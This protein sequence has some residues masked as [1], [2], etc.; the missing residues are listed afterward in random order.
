M[1]LVDT[2]VWIEHI[3][4]RVPRLAVALEEARVL[5]HPL[6]IGELAC[7]GIKSRRKFLDLMAELPLAPIV[8]HAEAIALIERRAL[9]GKGLSYGDVQLLASA[10]IADDVQLWTNDKKLLAAADA[11]GLA[12]RG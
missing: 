12:Y 1:I 6:V 10:A 3:H 5:T 11:M 2:S 9:M 7:G 4:V 8:N